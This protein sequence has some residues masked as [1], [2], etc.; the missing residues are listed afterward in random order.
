M[1][2]APIEL[3]FYGKFA[4]Y[5]VL[6]VAVL[7]PTYHYFVR[8]TWIGQLLN[9]RRYPYKPFFQSDLF[10]S[11]DQVQFEA[12]LA[13]DGTGGSPPPSNEDRSVLVDMPHR[14]PI[15]NLPLERIPQRDDAMDEA[16][17]GEPVRVT[18]SS[19]T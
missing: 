10:R 16:E 2:L 15:P 14:Q 11:N 1:Y 18:D 3:G 9:G 8:S 4:A 17:A 5:N 12:S 19:D 7:M 6:L 13:N